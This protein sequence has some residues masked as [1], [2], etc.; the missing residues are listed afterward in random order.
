MHLFRERAC[1][2]GV[3]LCIVSLIAAEGKWLSSEY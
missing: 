2:V 3:G 1:I